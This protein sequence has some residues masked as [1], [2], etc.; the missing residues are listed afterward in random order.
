M[1]SR[2]SDVALDQI[3]ALAKGPDKDL[4]NPVVEACTLAL[5]NPARA[6]SIWGIRLTKCSGRQRSRVSKRSFRTHDSVC[7]Q[8]V[9]KVSDR[10]GNSH[11]ASRFEL[12]T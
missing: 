3:A 4:Y 11:R 5:T 10:V 6:Q 2:V 7:E 8:Q 12:L 9:L 1:S